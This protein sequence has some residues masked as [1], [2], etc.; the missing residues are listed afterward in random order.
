M[1]H[2][3]LWVGLWTATISSAQVTFSKD[4]APIFY[5]HCVMCHR[6]GD[7]APMS[8]L[9]HQEARPWAKSIAKQIQQGTMPPW[10]G[11]SDHITFANDLS[12][13]QAEIE[14]IL[15]WVRDGAPAGSASG[16]TLK[17]TSVAAT[18]DDRLMWNDVKESPHVCELDPPCA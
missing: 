5:E 10:S 8:L 6:P 7:V 9:T 3:T 18:T 14:T 13:K 12:L 1:R 16:P 11:E 4:V 17:P 2:L 15:Q